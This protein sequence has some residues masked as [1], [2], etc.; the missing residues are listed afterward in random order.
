[1][2]DIDTVEFIKDKFLEI[3]AKSNSKHCEKYER[4]LEITIE[5]FTLMDD[6][7]Y[8]PR[9]YW[10]SKAIKKIAQ[11]YNLSYHR[12]V[13]IICDVMRKLRYITYKYE[14]IQ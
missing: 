2:N 1:M 6:Y 11:E 4:N 3:R 9:G 10:D 5:Y 12:V 7:R 13:L 8:N 14:I